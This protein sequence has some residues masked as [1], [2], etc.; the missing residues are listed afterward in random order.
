MSQAL[1][2]KIFQNG[3]LVE[4]KTLSQDVI[5]I[6]KLKSSH[7]CLED[8][9]VARMHAVIEVSGSDVRV[10]D[11]GSST[12]TIL[13]GRRVEKNDVL[14]SGDVLEFGP[15]RIEVEFA[16][17]AAQA[18]AGVTVVAAAPSAPTQVAA[19]M[20]MSA[21]M[22]MAPAGAT[23]VPQSAAPMAMAAPA[24]MPASQRPVMQI[25]ASEVEDQ[26][27]GRVAEV[28]TMYGRT[29][30]DAQHVGQVKSRVATAPIFLVVGG[31]IFVA[32]LGVLASEVAQDWEGHE[33]AQV[34]A[35]EKGLPMPQDPGLG[36]GGIAFGLMLLGIVP[37]GVGM[38]RLQDKGLQNY[39]LGESHNATFHLPGHGLPD[40]AAFPL[41][42]GGDH[43]Y[44]LQFTRE[45][46]G[47]VQL[48]GQKITLAELVA[49]G[50]A[51]APSVSAWLRARHDQAESL[52][53]D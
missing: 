50:R 46:T 43:D 33:K 30:L 21:P 38:A 2:L 45:M 49:S 32:G 17:L 16:A 29:V 13:N 44:Q 20:Q 53:S 52:A 10:I 15:F 1:S 42:R 24:A 5:K 34:Q 9:S 48:D 19:P 40:G 37:F 6:G 22:G 4:H 41:V 51:F 3:Q 35:A 31:L 23:M 25:D 27:G 39:T 7:L 18:P 47:D 8:D 26:S 14:K 12:G 36:L 11:L 28:V